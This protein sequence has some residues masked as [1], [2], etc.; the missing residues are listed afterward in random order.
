[1]SESTDIVKTASNF[2]QRRELEDKLDL[3]DYG[4]KEYKELTKKIDS[5]FGNETYYKQDVEIIEELVS[6]LISEKEKR[7]D[8]MDK[9]LR[10]ME[11]V[12]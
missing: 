12:K 9:Y 5:R 4:T 8:L 6:C 1:M 3:M 2:L 10:L 11:K 7:V